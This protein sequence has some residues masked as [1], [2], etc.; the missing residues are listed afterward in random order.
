[1]S[2][3]RPE[4]GT[5]PPGAGPPWPAPGNARPTPPSRCGW[6]EPPGARSPRPSATPPPGRPWSPP[7][8][9]WRSN[10]PPPETGSRC[11]RLAGARL[12]RLLRSVWP[13]AIDPEHPEQLIAVTKARE[14]VAE[15][16]K[17]FGLDAPTEIVV[18]NPTQTEL[19]AWVAQV[20]AAEPRRSPDESD[21][22]EG[23]WWKQE[24]PMPFR[25]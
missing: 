18:H 22:I 19:E 8:G 7:R 25:L 12:E 6:P 14:I 13:K 24:R 20:V 4:S 21:I 10:S 2:R 9:R 23:E 1:M 11:G 16:A 5:P 17:L 15:H 3:T